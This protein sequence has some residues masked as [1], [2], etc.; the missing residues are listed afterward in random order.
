MFPPTIATLEYGPNAARYFCSMLRKAKK[1]NALVL[2]PMFQV[3]AANSECNPT[4]YMLFRACWS[5]MCIFHDIL[6][7]FVYIFILLFFWDR[8]PMNY[9][10]W[11]STPSL[12][13][14]WPPK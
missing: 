13:L 12:V 5:E 4:D 3:L 8:I 9:S 2:F 10:D 14:S 11:P 7:L 1:I 6:L